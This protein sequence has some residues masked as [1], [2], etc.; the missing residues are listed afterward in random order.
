LTLAVLI[1]AGLLGGVGSV[2]R[3]V[4]DAAVSERRKGRFPVG[5]L[6]VN[7]S[8]SFALGV[9]VGTGLGSDGL[10]LL[11]AGL[12]GGYTTFST[13]MLDTQR[14][15]EDGARTAAAANLVVSLLAGLGAVWLG[16]ELGLALAA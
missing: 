10:R 2:G 7:V 1:G 8:G 5:I 3:V 15:A 6:V 16:R 4:L 11:G 12:I 14:L 13:W 9:L